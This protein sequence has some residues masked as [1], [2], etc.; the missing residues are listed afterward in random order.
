MEHARN[1]AVT[2]TAC[3]VGGCTSM[4]DIFLMKTIFIVFHQ[5]KYREETHMWHLLT[6]SHRVHAFSH[7][8]SEQACYADYAYAVIIS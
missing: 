6:N 7:P 8:F 1:A 2:T 5:L 4:H 3:V